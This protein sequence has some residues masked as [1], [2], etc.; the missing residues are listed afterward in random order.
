MPGVEPGRLEL[1]DEV[2]ILVVEGRGNVSQDVPRQLEAS[3]G[4]A[5]E[6]EVQ[7][8]VRH[9]RCEEVDRHG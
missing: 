2:A 4:E 7:P 8:I 6:G 5:L 1:L 9:D 3:M